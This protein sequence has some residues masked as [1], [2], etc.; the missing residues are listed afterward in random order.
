MGKRKA[1]K[2]E[3]H[4][5]DT[6]LALLDLCG[7]YVDATRMT[8]IDLL[9][10]LRIC[11]SRHNWW[12]VNSFVAQEFLELE[13]LMAKC[14]DQMMQYETKLADDYVEFIELSKMAVPTAWTYNKESLCSAYQ[15]QHALETTGLRKMT[16]A[17]D[18]IYYSA[19]PNDK[20]FDH[21]IESTT[22]CLHRYNLLHRVDFQEVVAICHRQNAAVTQQWFTF[23]EAKVTES[24]NRSEGGCS[25]LS[26]AVTSADGVLDAVRCFMQEAR[27][28]VTASFTT[29]LV[30]GSEGSGKTHLCDQIS[31]LAKETSSQ[32][33]RPRLPLD[34]LGSAVG[35]AEDT[36]V[37][38]FHAARVSITPVV[39]V[40]DGLDHILMEAST[41]ESAS[42]TGNL[43][44]LL[45]R[46]TAT[47][48]SVLDMMRVR[49][50]RGSNI[51][52]LCTSTRKT[53]VL[54]NRFDC[55]HHL[56][57]P[58]EIERKQL[59]ISFVP[60]V[61]DDVSMRDENRERIL[62]D[63]VEATLGKNY[64]ELVLC[65]RQ[66]LE[67]LS[68]Q[69]M[70][71]IS[72]RLFFDSLKNRLNTFA[73]LS[74]QSGVLAD[75]V[76]MRVL[77]ARDFTNTSSERFS[78]SMKGDISKLAWKV[79][80]ESIV[81]PMCRAKELTKLLVGS[82]TFTSKVVVGGALL[83]GESGSGKT[84]IA[85]D[86]G[87]YAVSLLPTIKILDVSCTSLIHK[88]VGG[89]ERAVQRL[90]DSA[91]KA[92]PCILL[93]EGIE[94]IAAVRGNDPTTEGTL[95]RVLATLLT[96][97]DGVNGN[98]QHEGGIAVIGITHNSALIDAAIKRPGRL[99]K[100]IE[101]QK[102]W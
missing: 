8:L 37:A 1:R 18:R 49:P 4:N 98:S 79:L 51:F 50:E 88:E 34:I 62:D 16:V 91:R 72:A 53:D 40:L 101:M 3:N 85:M 39:I 26:P 96:E 54:Y 75:S 83:T 6:I 17:L 92:S 5:D 64:A 52:V 93:L 97:M 74:V 78:F 9:E 66:A 48:L 33:I 42:S 70:R 87:Q 57:P 38:M 45:R 67:D 31:S 77:T 61:E 32:V 29:L 44:A 12:D 56:E 102:D 84:R 7:F 94:N 63:L 55:V 69:G 71:D 25:R 13:E 100:T 82:S 35:E 15:I 86:C 80:V 58:N 89:S 11:Y 28:T 46:S 68:N 20:S 21:C 95:D 47:F 73:P 27:E 10:A 76:D 36:V 14:R 60:I 65:C 81:I 2:R 59:L 30:V 41:K 24:R 90:F 99:Q 19:D 22:H 43:S 23:S